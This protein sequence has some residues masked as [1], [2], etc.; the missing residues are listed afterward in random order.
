MPSPF[1]AHADAAAGVHLTVFG[2]MVRYV[3]NDMHD[4]ATAADV[5]AIFRAGGEVRN[6]GEA[7]VIVREPTLWLP[8]DTA[9]QPWEGD[10]FEIDGTTW[11]VRTEPQRD[12]AFDRLTLSERG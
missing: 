3:P 7:E 11:K 4:G 2:Q 12:G 5:K 6:A 9:I 10:T 1:D 8:R